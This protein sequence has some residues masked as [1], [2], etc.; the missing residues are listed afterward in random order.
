MEAEWTSDKMLVSDNTTRHTTL[1]T[2]TWNITTMKASTLLTG[3]GRSKIM[4]L[5]YITPLACATW[6]THARSNHSSSYKHFTYECYWCSIQNSQLTSEWLLPKIQLTELQ[7]NP[8]S[9]YLVD[10]M[11]DLS[12]IY[13]LKLI[14]HDYE[15]NNYLLLDNT[16]GNPSILSDVDDKSER[17]VLS[18]NITKPQIYSEPMQEH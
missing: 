7:F 16:Q 4:L 12:V 3:K 14:Y 1:K 6:P 2:L 13:F 10:S 5:P 11:L 18:L 15:S 8:E 17:G 9:F